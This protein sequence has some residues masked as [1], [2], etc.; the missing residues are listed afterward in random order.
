MRSNS[1]P[2][3]DNN[4]YLD[5]TKEVNFKFYKEREYDIL[6]QFGVFK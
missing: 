2:K 3:K 4:I 1:L 6:K 5:Q